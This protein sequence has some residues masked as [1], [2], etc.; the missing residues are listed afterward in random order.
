MQSEGLTNAHVTFHFNIIQYQQCRNYMKTSII[1][2]IDSRIP[3]LIINQHIN[4]VYQVM[5]FLTSVTDNITLYIFFHYSSTP[6]F[7]TL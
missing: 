1:H 5:R 3:Q 7:I 6:S 4:I 2:S